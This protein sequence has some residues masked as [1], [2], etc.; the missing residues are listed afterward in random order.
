VKVPGSLGSAALG[1]VAV[2]VTVGWSLSAMVT[3]A[4]LGVP[5]V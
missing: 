2:M 4:L 5:T 1:S 3:V